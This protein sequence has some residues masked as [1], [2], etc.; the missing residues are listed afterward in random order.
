MSLNKDNIVYF[1]IM[2]LLYSEAGMVAACFLAILIYF[3]SKPKK[4]PS[5]SSSQERENFLQGLKDIL[6]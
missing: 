1:Y 4:P 3:P 6:W 5:L 2:C